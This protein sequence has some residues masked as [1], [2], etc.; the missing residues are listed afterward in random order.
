MK[1]Q[2]SGVTLAVSCKATVP[3]YKQ[4]LW[5]S[6]D[7]INV[8]VVVYMSTVPWGVPESLCGDVPSLY[9]DPSVPRLCRELL[10][11]LL[12]LNR[13]ALLV[14]PTA[15]RLGGGG[16]PSSAPSLYPVH[17]ITF[18]HRIS[19]P[20]WASPASVPEYRG[21]PPPALDS[22]SAT[23][24]ALPP[25]PSLPYLQRRSLS[26]VKTSFNVALSGF[27]VTVCL[28]HGPRRLQHPS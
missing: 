2:G 23:S 26:A 13:S 3:G 15:F 19:F 1:M 10:R 4:D 8:V 14:P 20:T 21:P 11:K 18:P 27:L 17:S 7:D 22:E 24:L 5:F 25:P 9:S 16:L 12:F 28:H 6:K